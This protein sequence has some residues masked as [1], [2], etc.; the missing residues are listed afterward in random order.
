[1][2]LVK[3]EPGFFFGLRKLVCLKVVS[4]ISTSCASARLEGE[5]GGRVRSAP[6]A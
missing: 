3:A 5:S 6:A 1:M 4:L 2:S